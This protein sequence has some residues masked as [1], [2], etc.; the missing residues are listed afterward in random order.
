MP[1]PN[2]IWFPDERIAF[3]CVPKCANTSLKVAICHAWGLKE[4]DYPGMNHWMNQLCEERGAIRI[5]SRA[6]LL[7]SSD[8]L[9]IAL[10]RH[11]FARLASYIRDKVWRDHVTAARIGIGRASSLEAIVS[12]ILAT[13]PQRC[14]HH[15][16][17]MAE[18]LTLDGEL[19]PDLLIRLED[20]ATGW[21][22]IRQTV[23]LWCGRDLGELP[24]VNVSA[25]PPITFTPGQSER[26][27]ERYRDD[28]ALFHYTPGV[29]PW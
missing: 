10:V 2:N 13:D 5:A 21:P 12:A 25:G 16:R 3:L 14:D 7:K 9:R 20:L 24:H 19:I 1:D 23:A 22:Q 18:L 17:A 28:L 27:G 15:Y 4:A 6:M 11:P 8:S 26:L 29:G